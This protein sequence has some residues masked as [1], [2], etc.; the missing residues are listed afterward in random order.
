M[1]RSAADCTAGDPRNTAQDLPLSPAPPAHLF[2]ASVKRRRG[3]F[4]P[5]TTYSTTACAHVSPR[6]A[7]GNGNASHRPATRV[8]GSQSLGIC[9]QWR[10]VL[11]RRSE[12]LTLEGRVP[13][14]G[15]VIR[16]RIGK[17][18]RPTGNTATACGSLVTSVSGLSVLAVVQYDEALPLSLISR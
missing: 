11:M 13:R 1:P 4:W 18:Q 7:C 17:H 3:Q 8:A 5:Y 15:N 14:D 16:L 6:S 2:Q 9:G 10:L 12:S